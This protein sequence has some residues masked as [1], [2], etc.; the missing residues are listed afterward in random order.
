MNIYNYVLYPEEHVQTSAVSA[1]SP[2]SHVGIKHP[3]KN[4]QT[5]PLFDLQK[6]DFPCQGILGTPGT[7]YF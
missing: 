6:S 2:E 3:W 7:F 1:P 4:K 5:K